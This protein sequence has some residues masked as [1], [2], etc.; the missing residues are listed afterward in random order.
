VWSY[1]SPVSGTACGTDASHQVI[2]M[3]NLFEEPGQFRVILLT[4]LPVGDSKLY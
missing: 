2:T 3:S 4:S 1:W